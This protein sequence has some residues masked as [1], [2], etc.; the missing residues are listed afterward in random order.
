VSDEAER[1]R[2]LN[3]ASWERTHVHLK[4]TGY[5]IAALPGDAAL[6]NRA[7]AG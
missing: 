7:W 6:I 2:D 1:W 5:D 3:R 4:P